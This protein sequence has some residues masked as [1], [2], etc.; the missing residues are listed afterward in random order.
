MEV[1]A[2]VGADGD[3]VVRHEDAAA[4]AAGVVGDAGLG[5]AAGGVDLGAVEQAVPALVVVV[6]DGGHG[7]VGR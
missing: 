5:G 2:G 4:V 7:G 3:E 6:E 1:L